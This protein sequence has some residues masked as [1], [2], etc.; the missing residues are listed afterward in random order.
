[1]QTAFSFAKTPV[2]GA[3]EGIARSRSRSGHGDIPPVN[4]P[5]FVRTEIDFEAAFAAILPANLPN[6]LP[7]GMVAGR[8][9]GVGGAVWLSPRSA[10]L[11]SRRPDA[12]RRAVARRAP[13]GRCCLVPGEENAP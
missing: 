2:E 6:A 12:A 11:P 1:M 9:G 4:P 10:S 8:S 5:L 7:P 3:N 13:F